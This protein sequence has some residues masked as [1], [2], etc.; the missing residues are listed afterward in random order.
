MVGERSRTMVGERSRTIDLVSFSFGSF[1]VACPE[2]RSLSFDHWAES[3]CR[4]AEGWRQKKMNRISNCEQNFQG[5]PVILS[6][7]G[8]PQGDL[9]LI[10]HPVS[11]WNLRRKLFKLKPI[12]S[13]VP[14][15]NPL[16]QEAI[17][18]D[19]WQSSTDNW[20]SKSKPLF[21]EA[22]L[23]DNWQLS[24]INQQLST[25]NYQLTTINQQLS[26]AP[27]GS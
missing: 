25:N 24:T 2:L 18:P 22:I 23:S 11:D 14:Q 6:G 13:W 8:L 3:K 1:S 7:V 5:K 9:C 26:T 21:Q 17:N 20:I 16:F 12:V 15:S 10:K 27:F 4:S 19:N